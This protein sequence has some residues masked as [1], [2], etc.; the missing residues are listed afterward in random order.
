MRL[1]R[2]VSHL[3]DTKRQNQ[4]SRVEFST[5]LVCLRHSRG[6]MP[7]SAHANQFLP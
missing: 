5:L 4:T 6:K 3:D 2:D 1:E 7:I